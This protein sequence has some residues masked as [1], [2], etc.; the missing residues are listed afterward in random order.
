MRVEDRQRTTGKS[1]CREKEEEQE[2]RSKE[3]QRKR[4]RKRWTGRDRI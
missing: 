1:Y 4:V 3:R 2:E